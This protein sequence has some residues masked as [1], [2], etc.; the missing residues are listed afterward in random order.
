[1]AS[2][3]RSRTQSHRLEKMA[4][5]REQAALLTWLAHL[6][7]AEKYLKI[8]MFTGYSSTTVALVLP[9]IGRAHV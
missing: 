1:M 4:I 2:V 7:K 5:A 3:L 9:E 6:L 8:G